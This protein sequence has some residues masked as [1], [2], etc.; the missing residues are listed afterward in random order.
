MKYKNTAQSRIFPL[1]TRTL[2]TIK[3]LIAR[4]HLI[5]AKKG[6]KVQTRDEDLSLLIKAEICS[7]AVKCLPCMILEWKDLSDFSDSL[8][9]AFTEQES[10][11]DSD[12][13]RVP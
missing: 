10:H 1:V 11:A 6:W 3:E 7:N 12:K 8:S 4:S 13:L 5:D 9:R 2:N